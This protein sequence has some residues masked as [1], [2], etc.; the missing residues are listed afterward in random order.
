MQNSKLKKIVDDFE[1][2]RPFGRGNDSMPL[3]LDLHWASVHIKSPIFRL[4]VLHGW[5]SDEGTFTG[6]RNLQFWTTE[7]PTN[8]VVPR[9]FLPDGVV[10]CDLPTSM[11]YHAFVE[12]SKIVGFVNPN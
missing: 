1:S 3:G 7:F 11:G 2:I 12:M 8:A 4:L 9:R 6:P 5:V 10:Q